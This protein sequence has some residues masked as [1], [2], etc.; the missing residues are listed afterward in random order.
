MTTIQKTD[1]WELVVETEAGPYGT[2][3]I[4]WSY[5]PTARRPE[6]QT[7]YK[8]VLQKD[9]LQKLQKVLAEALAAATI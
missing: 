4:F 7:Q 2:T 1:A 9:E 3:V 5:V 6:R 8:L